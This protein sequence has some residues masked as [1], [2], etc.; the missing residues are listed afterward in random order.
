MEVR[1]SQT[2]D[3]RKPGS[4]TMTA[5]SESDPIVTI[6][7]LLEGIHDQAELGLKEIK[8]GGWEAVEGLDSV[9]SAQSRPKIGLLVLSVDTFVSSQHVALFK[10][11]SLQPD[12]RGNLGANA[13]L[14]A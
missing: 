6:L 10:Y 1:H 3:R 13:E 14:A 11:V 8:N 9:A 2:A 4:I 7:R 5:N 12:I